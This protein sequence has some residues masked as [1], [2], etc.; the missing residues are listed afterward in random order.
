M[1]HICTGSLAMTIY[2]LDHKEPQTLFYIFISIKGLIL[3]M[4]YSV[5]PHLPVHYMDNCI[6]FLKAEIFVHI[7]ANK[8]EARTADQGL[9][10]NIHFGLHKHVSRDQ[11]MKRHK[12]NFALPRLPSGRG[13]KVPFFHIQ[14]AVAGY[15]VIAIPAPVSCSHQCWQHCHR[16]TANVTPLLVE[17]PLRFIREHRLSTENG[18]QKCNSLRRVWLCDGYVGGHYF[19]ENMVQKCLQASTGQIHNFNPVSKLNHQ[20]SLILAVCIFQK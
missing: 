10:Q 4:L 12:I 5:L 7:K 9:L 6:L 13:E 15:F 18:L 17:P 11:I 19:V 1:T 8:Q 14:A 2:N 16:S 3:L 20:L